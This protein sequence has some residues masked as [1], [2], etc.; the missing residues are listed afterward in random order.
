MG[1]HES[2]SIDHV[3]TARVSQRVHSN[4]DSKSMM[5]YGEGPWVYN[6][7]LDEEIHL[8]QRSKKPEMHAAKQGRWISLEKS[9][10]I[11]LICPFLSSI[12]MRTIIR[13]S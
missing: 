4:C 6:L 9:L 8:R 12:D 10:P 11:Y 7:W 1:L 3:T 13:R 5:S 2:P